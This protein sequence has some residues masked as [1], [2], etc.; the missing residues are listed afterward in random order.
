MNKDYF[1]DLFTFINEIELGSD[2][3]RA[4]MLDYAERLNKEELANEVYDRL[5]KLHDK[6]KMGYDQ[7]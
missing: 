1:L 5:R 3:D 7:D 4:F 6:K 2:F